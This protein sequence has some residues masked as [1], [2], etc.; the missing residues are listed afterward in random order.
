MVRVTRRLV[1]T[2]PARSAGELD[3]R[4]DVV[5]TAGREVA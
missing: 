3:E 4:G 1:A 2:A 5:L